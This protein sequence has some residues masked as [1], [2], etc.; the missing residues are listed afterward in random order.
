MSC[1]SSIWHEDSYPRPINPESSPITTRP[2]L[3]SLWSFF[4]ILILFIFILFIYKST[5]KIVYLKWDSNLDRRSRCEQTSDDNRLQGELIHCTYLW[6]GKLIFTLTIQRQI[7]D[8]FECDPRG[9]WHQWIEQKYNRKAINMTSKKSPNV[10]ISCPKMSSQEKWKIL[11]PLQ[12]LPKNVDD[13]GK[14]I[15]AT[16]FE[17]LPKV[18]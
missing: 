3:P 12:E 4:M 14:I 11:T 2:V 15:D 5:G 7:F 18:Q 9:F 1:P 10:Y 17:K 6:G 8:N 16:G 13:L